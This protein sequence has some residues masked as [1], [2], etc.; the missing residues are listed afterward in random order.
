MPETPASAFDVARRLISSLDC[1]CEIGTTEVMTPLECAEFKLEIA[2][3]NTAWAAPGVRV[4]PK[5][6]I[7][8]KGADNT[9]LLGTKSNL[10]ASRIEISGRDNIIIVGPRV[11]MRRDPVRIRR[12]ACRGRFGLHVRRPGCRADR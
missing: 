8:I 4:Y 2:D 1:I 9:V 6:E 12:A 5:S 11:K 3:K 10:S 7:T